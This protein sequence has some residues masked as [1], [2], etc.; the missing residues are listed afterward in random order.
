MLRN[1]QGMVLYDQHSENNAAHAAP[2][3]ST[4][5]CPKG[6]FSLDS[7]QPYLLMRRRKELVL[8]MQGSS[9][10]GTDLPLLVGKFG[11]AK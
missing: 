1:I 4:S 6:P 7:L 3:P 11:G 5:V 9:V 2:P 8:P 10:R